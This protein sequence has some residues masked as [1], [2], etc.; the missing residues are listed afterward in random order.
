MHDLLS[1]IRS[2]GHSQ[3]NAEVGKLIAET[4]RSAYFLTSK[5]EVSGANVPKVLTAAYALQSVEQHVKELGIEQLDLVVIH[6]P[7]E[8]PSNN[9]ALWKGLEQAVA[10]NL[11]RAIGLSNF[12]SS[13]IEPILEIAT[14]RPAVNQCDLRVGLAYSLCGFRDSA[15]AYNQAHNITFSAWATLK[16]CPVSNTDMIAIAKAH[17]KTTAQVCLRW[18]IDRGC[19]LAVGTGDDPAKATEYAKEDLDLF[20]FSLTAEEMKTINAIST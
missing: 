13:D 1:A 10:K 17:N 11:T 7:S 14:I 3:T 20:D 15:I 5:I 12:R 19:T 6:R 8:E 9:Q 18:I 16:M 4:P 2:F